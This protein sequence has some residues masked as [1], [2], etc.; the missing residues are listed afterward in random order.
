MK[1]RKICIDGKAGPKSF[2]HVIN[3]VKLADCQRRTIYRT[4]LYVVFIYIQHWYM[5]SIK[6]SIV[7]VFY[8][9]FIDGY[10][11]D[12]DVRLTKRKKKLTCER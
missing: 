1:K 8:N 10:N 2:Q 6:I 7:K 5:S 3:L 4:L 11:P 9:N 12:K